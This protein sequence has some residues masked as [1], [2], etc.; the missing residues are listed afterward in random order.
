MHPQ[1]H[2]EYF[3]PDFPT[4]SPVEGFRRLQ[5]GLN[6]VPDTFQ[7]TDRSPTDT[8]AS[9]NIFPSAEMLHSGEPQVL[10]ESL[11]PALCPCCVLLFLE[12]NIFQESTIRDWNTR[13]HEIS[14]RA[15]DILLSPSL[16]LRNPRQLN[17][18]NHSRYIDI[19]GMPTTRL[20]DIP[21]F[22][23]LTNRPNAYFDRYD[24]TSRPS[25]PWIR[26][27][28]GFL[29]YHPELLTLAFEKHFTH[30]GLMHALNYLLAGLTGVRIY[31]NNLHFITLSDIDIPETPGTP[32]IRLALTN[33]PRFIHQFQQTTHL[34][35]SD[36]QNRIRLI[37]AIRPDFAQ[38]AIRRNTDPTSFVLSQRSM[39]LFLHRISTIPTAQ[40]PPYYSLPFYP[41]TTPQPTFTMIYDPVI[42]S[43]VSTLSILGSNAQADVLAQADVV[44]LNVVLDSGAPFSEHAGYHRAIHTPP[45]SAEEQIFGGDSDSDIPELIAISRE[46]SL[47]YASPEP[48]AGSTKAYP[49]Y[50]SYPS[51]SSSYSYSCPIP[52]SSNYSKRRRVKQSSRPVLSRKGKGQRQQA[53]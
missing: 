39:A 45:E 22:F 34:H 44:A 8:P 32:D 4:N 38:E 30:L 7:I 2:E 17:I 10:P 20:D 43:A 16:V 50:S 13:A 42:T 36:E 5:L 40:V 28:V 25:R 52:G 21:N 51:S 24:S 37:L 9:P 41:G 46:P 35:S 18:S 19:R 6:N 12:T 27:M 23:L 14:H 26:T 33:P 11:D 15:N 53:G 1:A 49:I 29:T 31:H 47:E 48:A 3:P